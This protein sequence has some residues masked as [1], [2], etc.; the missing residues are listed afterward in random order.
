MDITAQELNRFDAVSARMLGIGVLSSAVCL[1][2]G[3]WLWAFSLEP[4]AT[5][6]LDTG[7]LILMATPA[8]RVVVSLIV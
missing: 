8:A 1:A 7:L 4:W 3:L 2:T 5:R 6:T